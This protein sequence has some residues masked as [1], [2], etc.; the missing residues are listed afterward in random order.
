M[1]NLFALR[2]PDNPDA[3][4]TTYG[5]GALLRIQGAPTEAGAYADSATAAIV[6]GVTSYPVWDAAGA[7]GWWYA[8]RY[9]A[10]GGVPAGAWSTPFVPVPGRG[11]YGT[12]AGLRAFLGLGS[13]SDPTNDPLLWTALWAASWAI[14]STCDRDFSLPTGAAENRRFALSSYLPPIIEIDDLVDGTDL[15]VAFDDGSGTYPLTVTTAYDLAPLNAPVRGFPYT[16]IEFRTFTPVPAWRLGGPLVAVTSA[17]WGWPA[18]P[19]AVEQAAYLQAARLYKRKDSPFGIA[20]S[21]VE[22]NVL[23][24]LAKLDP[25]VQLLLGGDLLRTPGLVG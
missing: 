18:I 10:A 22:G 3:L 21:P 2:I 4:L 7:P 23:R 6:S 5:P 15:S 16:R 12:L 13:G 11:L 8:Y 19:P 14:Q 24:L 9:E 17:R 20:G 1:S 25:D